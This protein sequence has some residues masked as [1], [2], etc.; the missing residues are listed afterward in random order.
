[1]TLISSSFPALMEQILTDARYPLTAC[2][3][4]WMAFSAGAQLPGREE[5]DT[6]AARVMLVSAGK[7]A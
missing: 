6:S 5:F 7:A 4:A 3:A 2:S 1:M